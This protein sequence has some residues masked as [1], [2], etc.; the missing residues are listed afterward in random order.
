MNI[1]ITLTEEEQEMFLQI[2]EQIEAERPLK[3]TDLHTIALLV[4]NI[5]LYNMAH[6]DIVCTGMYIQTEQGGAKSN[7]AVAVRDQA[8]RLIK[9]CMSELLMTPRSKVA[10]K[11]LA[12]EKDEQDPLMEAL[13]ARAKR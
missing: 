12:A 6:N 4:N 5:A 8:S 9:H 1:H 7:P 10:A 13:K 3:P 2:K 11:E